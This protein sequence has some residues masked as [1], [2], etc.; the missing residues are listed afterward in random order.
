MPGLSE[1]QRRELQ[2]LRIANALDR[3]ERENS[4]H[5]TGRLAA[6]GTLAAAVIAFGAFLLSMTKNDVAPAPAITITNTNNAATHQDISG[7]TSLT[8][9]NVAP[10]ATK[11]REPS[12]PTAAVSDY[13]KY[14]DSN[15]HRLAGTTNVAIALRGLPG[16]PPG[17]LESAVQ[18]ALRE[19]GFRIVPIFRNQF[20]ED[21]AELRLFNGDASF[22]SRLKLQEHC[23]SVL[24]G[25]LRFAGPAQAVDG[26]MY[27]REAVLE[28][29]AL[30][31]S[32][33]LVIDSLEISEKGGGTTAEL[34]AIAALSRL[35]E[36]VLA[37][38]SGWSWV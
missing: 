25:V 21:E 9:P 5:A 30:D 15:V 4:R 24:L 23:D 6:M 33:G 29:R 1:E 11:A 26:G 12:S 2:D 13:K 35:K 19:R 14:I 20:R 10:A 27:I 7:S 18:R 3:R 8:I 34:S 16:F 38:I 37:N 32:T 17:A 22:A 31:P 36:S 28:I